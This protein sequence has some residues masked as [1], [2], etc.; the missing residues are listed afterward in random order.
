MITKSPEN[1]DKFVNNIIYTKS[2]RVSFELLLKYLDFKKD[3]KILIPAYIGITDREGS[4]VIDPIENCK[5]NYEFYS[6]NRK[7]RCDFEEISNKICTNKIKVL[8]IIHY[9]GFLHCDIAKIQKLCK[10][11]G[12]ILIEDCAHVNGSSHKGIL[13]G[14][15]GDY[16][17]FSIH[18][19][20]ATNDGGFLKINKK[21]TKI[22]RINPDNDI[23]V[24][25]LKMFVN[26]DKEKINTTKLNNYKYFVEKLKNIAGLEI[27]FPKIAEGNIP[28]NLP[29]IILN[30]KREKLYFKLLEY[31]IP[32]IALY[33]RLI[34]EINPEL[35]F[36]SYFLSQNIL[37]LPIN[38]DL[39]WN[40]IEGIS[41]TI[42]EIMKTL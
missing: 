20:F 32:T 17:F 40:D 16:S 15:Y 41:N 2:A 6:I 31:N 21:S 29:L 13:L 14:D 18:K 25:S 1:T 4:G 37:N 28:L 23:P 33:Y 5:I 36:N 19:I 24:E 12:V 9:F 27:I 11:K 30:G 42:S 10:E 3:E 39:N 22:P 34:E 8:L 38:Q 26:S 7:F 35:Y